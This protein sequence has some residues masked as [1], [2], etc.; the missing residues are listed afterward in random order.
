MKGNVSVVPPETAF[1]V[2]SSVGENVIVF[3][4]TLAFEIGFPSNVQ[5][6]L[7]LTPNAVNVLSSPAHKSS[8]LSD[9]IF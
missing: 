7:P 2:P 9:T 8:P 6:T 5:V 1:R 3:P 4:E